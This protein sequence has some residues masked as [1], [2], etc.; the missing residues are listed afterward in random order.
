MNITF[1]FA[2]I[3]CLAAG[4][5]AYPSTALADT[6]RPDD[7]PPA[8]FPLV[9][10]APEATVGDDQP[11]LDV[12][13]ANSNIYYKTL[14]GLDFH[15][16]ASDLTYSSTNG[17]LFPLALVA[18]YGFAAAF[19]LPS[20]ASVTGI[21][22]FVVDSSASE[23]INLS[24]SR[25]TPATNESLTMSLTSTAGNSAS[26]QA[27]SLSS[28]LPFTITNSTYAYRLRVEFF[29]VGGAQVLYGA[30]ITYTLPSPAPTG[31]DFVTM[32]GADFRSSSSNMT[33]TALG[34][35]LYANTIDSSYYFQTRLDLPDGATINE[36][37]WI[38]I[39]N[40]PGSMSLHV[41]SHTPASDSLNILM[42]PTNPLNSPNVQVITSAA[43][44]TVDNKNKAY[45]IGFTPTAASANLRIVGARV[46]YTP[47][48]S[49]D[50]S[51]VQI[52]TFTGVHFYPS[53]SNLTYRA[54]GAKLY[55]L[56]LSSGRSFQ[57]NLNLP[58]NVRI[59]KITFYFKDQSDQ[60]IAFTGR[61]YYPATEGYSDPVTGS[62]TG[63]LPTSVRVITFSDI[64]PVMGGFNTY[65]MVSRLRAVLG[66]AGNTQY[67]IGAQ[68]E[69]SYS[70]VYLPLTVKE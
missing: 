15:P 4:L 23:E 69:Y 25:F 31:D 43:S 13:P 17:G 26:I 32:A 54:S 48:S 10:G 41:F 5:F 24:V 58:S 55:A 40:D 51:A 33:Y 21:T 9:D 61:Y 1:R 42:S 68:V 36:V 27:I 28:G 56:A 14:T 63:N 29:A 3:L 70:K 35:T 45:F 50:V 8:G 49:I 22:F 62:S 46:R 20:G 2:L 47:P 64:G 39:D 65:D 59:N 19:H 7:P 11:V 60:D 67:L 6:V 44:I 37:Q 30:R 12:L 52:K 66:T 57:V 18:S 34:G 38:L 16:L 53:G